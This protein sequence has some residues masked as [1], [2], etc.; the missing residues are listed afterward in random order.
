MLPQ[1]TT[2]TGYV[3]TTP[4]YGTTTYNQVTPVNYNCTIKLAAGGDGVLKHWEYD[5]NPGGCGAL[6][7]RLRNFAKSQGKL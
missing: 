6:S 1:T 5:G 2:T 3:G 7:D 4:V